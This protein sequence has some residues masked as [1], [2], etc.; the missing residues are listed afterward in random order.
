VAEIM[1]RHRELRDPNVLENLRE[2]DNELVSKTA[3]SIKE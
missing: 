3:Q 1:R 2:D